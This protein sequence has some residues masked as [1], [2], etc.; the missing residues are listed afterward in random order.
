MVV[1]FYMMLRTRIGESRNI[2]HAALKIEGVKIAHSVMGNYNVIL[3]AEGKDL[4]EVRL[5]RVAVEQISGITVTET[6]IHA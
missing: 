6:A 2:V 5:I 3:F 1:P 4:E